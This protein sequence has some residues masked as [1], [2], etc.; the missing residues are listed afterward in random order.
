MSRK[1]IPKPSLLDKCEYFGVRDRCKVWR[2]QDRE[3]Y[4]TWDALHGEIEAFDKRG[5]HPGVVDTITGVALKPA[6]KGSSGINRT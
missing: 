3:R 6:I 1:P 4:Y 2:S 5:M